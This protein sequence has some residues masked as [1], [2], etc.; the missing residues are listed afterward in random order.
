[1]TVTPQILGKK[2]LVVCICKKRVFFLAPDSDLVLT[3]SIRL[4]R[5]SPQLDEGLSL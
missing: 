1:M 4:N 5:D 2:G 3:V